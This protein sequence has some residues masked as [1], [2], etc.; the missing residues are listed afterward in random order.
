MTTSLGPDVIEHVIGLTGELSLRLPAGSVELRGT[1][2]D[3]A[4]IRDLDGEPIEDRFQIDRE[5]NRLALRLRD[6]FHI[7]FSGLLRGGLRRASTRL[8]VELPR[9]AKL[10][11]DCA[12]ADI[13]ASE[14]RGEQR[15]HSASGSIRLSAVAGRVIAESVSGAVD[16]AAVGDL[17][18]AGR[19]VS[20][21]IAVRGGRLPS[22]VLASTS[23]DIEIDALLDGPG[24]YGIQTVSGDAQVQA[25]GGIRIE[26]KTVTGEIVGRA[27]QRA[28]SRRGKHHLVVGDGRDLLTFKSI[29]GD[30]RIAD[31]E[32]ASGVA[33][34]P[35]APEPPAPPQ[36]LQPPQP[37]Q[38][39]T[40]P[41]EPEAHES[42]R[43]AILRDLENGTIDVAE[44]GG[45]LAALEGESSD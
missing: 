45:R 30:L 9:G 35:A 32:S 25:H 29:S 23:G 20:G 3:A 5:P 22:M 40:T 8:E 7:D 44:A 41:A 14:L 17:H 33:V 11:I 26:G 1:D 43:L 31:P 21:D 38:P 19:S 24:P 42:E 18:L 34:S 4:R 10:D 36:A 37:P 16:I 13:T 28:E 6:G 27:Q 39:P 15:Y 2:G 12:S